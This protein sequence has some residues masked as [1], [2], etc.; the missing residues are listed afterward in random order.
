MKIIYEISNNVHSMLLFEI[1]SVQ[2][3]GATKEDCYN[4]LIDRV[5]YYIDEFKDIKKVAMGNIN[6]NFT[7]DERDSY[8]C[9]CESLMSK[10]VNNSGYVEYYCSNF[11]CPK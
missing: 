2:S 3:F 8:C 9:R 1:P 4:A 10:V 5:C 11:G 6:L 7:D